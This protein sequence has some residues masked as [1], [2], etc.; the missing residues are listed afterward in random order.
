M[1][2]W[3]KSMAIPAPSPSFRRR[4]W[5]RKAALPEPFLSTCRL[6]SRRS[7]RSFFEHLLIVSCAS[8]NPV[9]SSA[10][11]TRRRTE[12]SIG[13]ARPSFSSEPVPFEL[14]QS[15]GGCNA[16]IACSSDGVAR[17]CFR[18][19]ADSQPRRRGGI[20]QRT[21]E[22]FQPGRIGASGPNRPA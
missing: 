11:T 17:H 1:A 6:F 21:L 20:G 16:Q 9:S 15:N 3:W 18:V 4:S 7:C 19:T 12:S 8:R 10:G 22:I 2:P 5:R 14:F 13:N